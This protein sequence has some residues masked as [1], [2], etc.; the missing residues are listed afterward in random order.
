MRGD[1]PVD[2]R[3]SSETDTGVL[4]EE[5]FETACLEADPCL[6]L[7]TAARSTCVCK[8]ITSDTYAS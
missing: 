6:A 3:G 1:L 2:S 5:S 8:K 7:P 4:M